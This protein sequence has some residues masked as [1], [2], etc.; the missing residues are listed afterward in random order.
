MSRGAGRAA[1]ASNQDSE[2]VVAEFLPFIRYAA[3]RLAWRLPPSLSEEDLVSAGVAGLLEA[4]HRYDGGRVKLRTF[5]EYRIRGAMLD[6]LRAADR[7]PRSARDRMRAARSAHARLE[8]R[9]GRLPDDAE[10][11]QEMGISL[12]EYQRILGE[13]GRAALQSFEGLELRGKGEVTPA[14]LENTAGGPLDDPLVRLEAA[15]ERDAVAR[16]I[17]ELPEKERLVLSLYYW[18]EMTMKEVGAV[19]GLSEGRVCQLHSQAIL[20]IRARLEPEPV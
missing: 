12:Q 1:V 17:Q 8:R 19:L 15:Q 10:V 2:Q 4:L 13:I 20:R 7:V 5:A 9:L 16:V 11:A 18:E 14:E 6:T 3:R